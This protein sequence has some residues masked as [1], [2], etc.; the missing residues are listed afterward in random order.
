MKMT[1]C[2]TTSAAAPIIHQPRGQTN[3]ADDRGERQE[4]SQQPHQA[5]AAR[6]GLRQLRQV[7]V[8][9][10]LGRPHQVNQA[11]N[12]DDECEHPAHDETPSD[13]VPTASRCRGA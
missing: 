3:N 9:E 4:R 2:E 5:H 11:V 13:G 12:D 10:R 1:A 8:A 7:G 6:D